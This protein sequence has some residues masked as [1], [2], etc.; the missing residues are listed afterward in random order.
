[1]STQALLVVMLVRYIY[2]N[3]LNPFDL[4]NKKGT[5]PLVKNRDKNFDHQIDMANL[6]SLE[7]RLV[8]L[9]SLFGSEVNVQINIRH[10]QATITAIERPEV[11]SERKVP[12]KN[13]G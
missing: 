10:Q 5:M 1:M 13:I 9:E 8:L 6:T 11:I 12:D 4:L 7:E 3:N 2:N